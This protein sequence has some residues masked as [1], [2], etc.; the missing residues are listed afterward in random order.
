MDNL[1]QGAS[2]GSA[3]VASVEEI[4]TP[5][6]PQKTEARED[7]RDAM[8]VVVIRGAWMHSGP[9]VSA[10]IVG[11]HPIGK[12]LHPVSSEQGWD[13]V[14]GPTTAQRGWIYAKYYLE[15]IDGP[16]KRMAVEDAQAPIKASEA[17]E[18]RRPLVTCLL[19]ALATVSRACWRRSFGGSELPPNSVLRRTI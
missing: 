5:A 13:E 1:E 4:F 10:P 18:L 17:S 15:P 3:P 19:A 14:F 8:W 11:H 6:L 7:R 12:G 2:K 16:R 9:S